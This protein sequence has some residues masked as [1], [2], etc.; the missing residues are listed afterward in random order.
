MQSPVDSCSLCRKEKMQADK[1][2][3]QTTEIPN[4][5]FVEVSIDLILEMPTSHYGNKN[6]L[7]MVDHLTNWPMVKAIPDKE[8]TT[9]A[10]AIFDKLILEHGNPEILLYHKGKEFSNDTLAYVF[11]EFV[12]GQ[13]LFHLTFPDPMARQRILTS[14]SR[15]QYKT[16]SR[17]QSLMGSSP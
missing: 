5:A 13:H 10:N 14:F 17:R 6:I 9:V 12:L 16:V 15:P 4:R 11:Q 2:Q 7:V 1:Y 3:L 8:A